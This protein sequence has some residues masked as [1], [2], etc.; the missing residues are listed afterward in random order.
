MSV[1]GLISAGGLGAN[2]HRHGPTINHIAELDVVTGSGQLSRCTATADPELF[3]AVLGGLGR[4]GIIARATVELRPVPARVRT[5]HL[6]YLDSQAWFAD[7]RRVVRDGRAEFVE[8]MCWMGAKGFRRPT[9]TSSRVQWLYGLQI[10]IEYEGPAPE[11]RAA[12]AG[13]SP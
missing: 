13:L 6:I 3:S 10:G 12:L 9:E 8:A 7:Q 4:F 2:S 1:A 5:F 11:R